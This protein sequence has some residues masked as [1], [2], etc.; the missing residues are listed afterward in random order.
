MKKKLMLLLSAAMTA[1]VALSGCG[2][3]GAADS[4]AVRESAGANVQG[5]AGSILRRGSGGG[6]C[7]LS[8]QRFKSRHSNG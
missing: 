6:Y 1:S 8:D 2:G 7:R 3:K 4:G 5:A